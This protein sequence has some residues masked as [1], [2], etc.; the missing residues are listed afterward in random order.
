MGKNKTQ[1]GFAIPEPY[2]PAG[3]ARMLYATT[4]TATNSCLSSCVTA[5]GVLYGSDVVS[6]G[7]L[8]PA[9]I[10][11][12][13]NMGGLNVGVDLG[14]YYDPSSV[15]MRA[16][17]MAAT[18]DGGVVTAPS[19]A[20]GPSLFPAFGSVD[21]DKTP[22]TQ[23][24]PHG[25]LAIQPLEWDVCDN[26][27]V[28]GIRSTVCT[29]PYAFAQ[30]LASLLVTASAARRVRDG[31][32]AAGVIRVSPR[33]RDASRSITAACACFI[34]G[35]AE[36]YAGL[37]QFANRF[38][39]TS[40]VQ[41][42]DVGR[43]VVNLTA[44]YVSEVLRDTRSQVIANARVN[45]AR[46]EGTRAYLQPRFASDDD[47]VDDELDAAAMLGLPNTLPG[48]GVQVSLEDSAFAARALLDPR[49]CYANRLSMICQTGLPIGAAPCVLNDD[50]VGDFVQKTRFCA[51]N[52][53]CAGFPNSSITAFVL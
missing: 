20:H 37:A 36:N 47:V 44:L 13:G 1:G 48:T 9:A 18:A 3:N 16:P 8:G 17:V 19:M 38:A 31:L 10:A 30:S 49:A 33:L 23:F 39:D 15:S 14:V 52:R 22:R 4:G 28:C 6:P 24:A 12:V 29:P 42:L 25:Q 11:R 26:A 46:A 7:A 21:S 51:D 27:C 41:L 40:I 35:G 2:S 32:E 43:E 5:P 34:M 45:Y 50:D 53:N